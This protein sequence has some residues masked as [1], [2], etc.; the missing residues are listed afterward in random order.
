[1]V[2]AAEQLVLTAVVVNQAIAMIPA[3]VFQDEPRRGV[4]QVR[5]SVPIFGIPKIHLHLGPW[6]ASLDQKPAEPGFHRGFGRRRHRGEALQLSAPEGFRGRQ[7][8]TQRRVHG[9][10]NFHRR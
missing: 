7:L 2:A 6:Q 3:V 9:D 1:L 8:L 10:E 4:V 5:P